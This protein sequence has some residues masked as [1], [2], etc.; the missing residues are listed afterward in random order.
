M[1]R[2]F[3]ASGRIFRLILPK[4]YTRGWQHWK[5]EEGLGP[6]KGVKWENLKCW[7]SISALLIYRSLSHHF[8]SGYF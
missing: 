8:P 6:T 7:I 4:T 3:Y 5:R 2:Y 1:G